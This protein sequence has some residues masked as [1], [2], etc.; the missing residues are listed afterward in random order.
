MFK[1]HGI[2][3]IPIFSDK[4][5]VGVLDESDLILPLAT[6]RLKPT[7]PIIHL[8]KGSIIW[9]NEEDSLESL[10]EH[11]HKGLIALLKD[12]KKNYM[13]LQKSTYLTL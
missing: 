1:K 13:L 8:I 2:S 6:G 11:F 3:H 10:S 9:V 12:Q 7:E 5:L 4:E